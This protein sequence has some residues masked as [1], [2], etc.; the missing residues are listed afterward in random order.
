[1]NHD[2]SKAIQ[3]TQRILDA[4]HPICAGPGLRRINTC[5]LQTGAGPRAVA[6]RLS[7]M[8]EAQRICHAVPTPNVRWLDRCEVAA[9]PA[10][11]SE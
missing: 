6:L 3:V 10:R 1:M 5:P 8:E 2:P 7:Q 9:A 11:K 4:S